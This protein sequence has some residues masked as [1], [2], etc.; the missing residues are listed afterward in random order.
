MG[1][2]TFSEGGNWSIEGLALI[3][4][5]VY[6][7]IGRIAKF[8]AFESNAHIFRSRP[9]VQ[10]VV[11]G[12]IGRSPRMQY[13]ALSLVDAGCQVDLI[14][15]AETTPNIRVTL[16]RNIRIRPLRQAWSIPEG[17]PKLFYLL[18]APFKALFVAV[19]LLWIMGG[20]TQYPDFIFMQNPPAIPTLVIAQFISWAR[21]AWLVIDWHNFGYS[22]LA[23][24]FGK[25]HRIVEF[26]KWYEQKF[27]HKA[28]AHLTVTDK[29]KA[30]LTSWGV[31][32]KL[33]TFKDRPMAHF[34]KLTIERQHDL[35]ARLKLEELIKSQNLNADEFVG[36]LDA[37]TTI[38]TQK[39]NGVVKY[40]NDRIR[41][42]ISST[43]WTEDEDFQLLLDAVSKY[44]DR[45]R[46][47]PTSKYPKLLF[48][49]TGKGP[50]K[51]H[52]EELI[53]KMSLNRTR[54]ITVWLESVDYPL[55]LGTADLGVSL[56]KSTSGMDLPMKVVDMFGC[57]LPACAVNFECLNELVH[58]GENGMVFDTSDEL[59]SQF[60]E[61]FAQDGEKL[62]QL[63]KNV[64]EEY[65][66]QSWEIQWKEKLPQLFID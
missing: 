46:G 62:K 31:R 40:R 60:E 57:G 66:N 32:G 20:V 21:N 5:I 24:K 23:M 50:L 52:Y 47:Q 51:S 14:G 49:I 7:L 18:W 61:L 38:L 6:V 39:E 12:D 37:E 64:Q 35:L 3:F 9:V 42:I 22:M 63:A 65:K 53:S 33:I 25:D 59:E 36:S 26:A 29:M 43:S 4:L 27:G 19:Q 15:Y 45:A 48:V 44:E 11:M 56:H 16:S 34:D 28:Y 41:M 17:K 10:V 54:I 1:N 2:F 55:L 30:E 13:H 58:H 8:Y